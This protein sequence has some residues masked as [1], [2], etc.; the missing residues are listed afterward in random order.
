[1]PNHSFHMGNKQA[2][3]NSILPCGESSR[4]LHFK[5]PKEEVCVYMI[6]F[7]FSSI[8][9]LWFITYWESFTLLPTCN[10]PHW[11]QVSTTCG[12]CS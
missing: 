10:Y 11:V 1:M 3:V 7:H 8:Q 12:D 9:V 2:S 4:I 5:K 6:A